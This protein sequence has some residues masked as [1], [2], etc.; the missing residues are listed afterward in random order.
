MSLFT[1]EEICEGCENAVFHDC[2][3]RFCRCRVDANPDH[4][5][6]KCSEKIEEIHNKYHF[7]NRVTSGAEEK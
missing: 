7:G 4:I 1:F 3:G 6:G 2:C 5:R